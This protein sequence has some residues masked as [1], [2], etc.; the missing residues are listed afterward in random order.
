MLVLVNT[1][2]LL[3]RA[4]RDLMWERGYVGTSPR[5]ILDRAGV[6]Q[7]SMY[8]HFRGKSHLA[9]EVLEGNRDALLASG[10]RYFTAQG[11]VF[12][13]ISAYLLGERSVLKGCK[14]GRMTEDYQV[15]ND[16]NLRQPVQEMFSWFREQVTDLL[17]EGQRSGEFRMTFTPARVASTVVA[18]LQGAYVLAKAADATEPFDEAITG[19]LELLEG[20][21][22]QARAA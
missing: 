7:G 14:V 16:P 19:V 20:Q 5:D 10:E 4:T 6:G 9:L 11:T 18:T 13:R 3:V 1:R 12:E 8:H 22:E 2:E 21:L 15:M 17:A